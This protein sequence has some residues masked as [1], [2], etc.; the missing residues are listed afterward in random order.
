MLYTIIA[1]IMIV[2]AQSS[3]YHNDGNKDHF[4]QAQAASTLIYP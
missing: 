2:K 1:T 4:S 3:V